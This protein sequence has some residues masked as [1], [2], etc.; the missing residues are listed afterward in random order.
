[1][2][3]DFGFIPVVHIAPSTIHGNLVVKIQHLITR[4]S[5]GSGLGAIIVGDRLDDAVAADSGRSRD[6]DRRLKSSESGGYRT[7]CG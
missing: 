4:P 6:D 2:D 3:C 5:V 1:L 7:A